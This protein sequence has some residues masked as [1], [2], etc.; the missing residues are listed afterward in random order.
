MHNL[1]FITFTLIVLIIL[2]KYLDNLK[3]TSSYRITDFQVEIFLIL[4]FAAIPSN[5]KSEEMI[6]PVI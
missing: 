4:C 3:V 2:G 5:S 6:H 1:V